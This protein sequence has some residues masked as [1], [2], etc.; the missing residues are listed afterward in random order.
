[1]PRDVDAL[2]DE[3]VG[4]GRKGAA[5]RKLLDAAEAVVGHVVAAD[6]QRLRLA[7]APVV[8]TLV[9][10]SVLLVIYVGVKIGYVAVDDRTV[11]YFDLLIV[12]DAVSE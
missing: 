4:R 8:E 5:M 7:A 6:E 10:E 2:G 11:G 1:M 9:V 3:I 12:A